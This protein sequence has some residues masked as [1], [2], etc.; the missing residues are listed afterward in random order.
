MNLLS[1]DHCK[2]CDYRLLNLSK[3]ILCGLTDE[4]P[5]FSNK[6]SK[7]N[8]KDT[9]KSEIEDINTKLE[10]AKKIKKEARLH[11][12][13]YLVTSLLVIVVAFL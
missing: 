10:V 12:T 2:F 8:L 1:T 6:C 13:F 4:R 9:Y 5:I 11:S 7:I 3:G